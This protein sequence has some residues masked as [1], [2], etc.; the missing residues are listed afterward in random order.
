VAAGAVGGVALAAPGDLTFKRCVEDTLGPEDCG[1]ESVA[2]NG[3]NDLALS[4][5]GRSLYVPAI[6]GNSVAHLRVNER[7]GRLRPDDAGCIDDPAGA[8]LCPRRAVGL[9]GVGSAT[10]SPD[11]KHVYTTAAGSRLVILKR[12]GSGAL[13]RNECIEDDVNGFG[14]CTKTAPGLLG[15]SSV[16]ISPD[17]RFAYGVGS[18]DDAISLFRRN[19]T[20][21]KLRS[22]GCVEDG[23]RSLTPDSSGCARTAGGL[24]G[25]TDLAF[26][27]GNRSLYYAGSLSDTVGRLARRRDNGRLR[28]RECVA[29]ENTGT[30][31][32]AIE[33]QGLDG[34]N[35]LVLDS[36]RRYLHVSSGNGFESSIATLKL[37]GQAGELRPRECLADADS[38]PP[39]GCT[40]EADGL[41]VVN[42]L[43]MSPDD[44]FLYGRAS[45]DDSVVTLKRNPRNGRLSDR[46]CI[47][48]DDAP[49]P[50][51]DC[52]AEAETLNG[53][54]SILITSNGRWLLTVSQIE[55]AVSVFRRQP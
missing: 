11:G 34:P 4:P 26:G 6:F 12:T 14:V 7:L 49:A 2:L 48:D 38:G 16:V 22:L 46:G 31:G 39:A 28:P 53:G 52:A 3:A 43:A 42:G 27:R 24:D 47:A 23:P 35:S 18:A 36:T 45:I 15:V 1:R 19:A 9:S 5:D 50:G 32:C 21:G 10:V 30:G 40:R 13:R 20:T 54:G 8:D 41:E 17:G 33:M 37:R 25:V 55:D 51:S 29:D 44:R